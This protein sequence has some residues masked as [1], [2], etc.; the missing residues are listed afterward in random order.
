MTTSTQ[1]PILI[2]S[3]YRTGS[4]LLRFIVDTHPQIYSPPEVAL[5]RTAY[6][7]VRFAIGV[8]G[9]TVEKDQLAAMPPEVLS[10]V[11]AILEGEMSA[12]AAR[13]GKEIWCEKTPSNLLPENLTILRQVFPDARYLCLHRHC[14]DVVPSLLKMAD[15]IQELQ[16]YLMKGG[17]LTA[18]INFWNDVTATLLQH[19]QEHGSRCFRLRYEDMV[20]EPTKVLEPMFRFLGVDWDESLVTGVFTAQHDRGSDDHY[21]SFTNSIHTRSIGSGRSL[22]L[23]GVPEKTLEV[24]RSL[25][26]R[27]GYPE[28]PAATSAA[29]EAVPV[30]DLRWFFE[31]HLPAR[32]RKEPDLCA[33]IAGSYQFVVTGDRGGAWV[34]VPR[35]CRIA[36]GPAAASCS[37]EVSAADLFAIAS[38]ELHPWK[39]AELRR[40]RLSG[41]V[42]P[43]ELE[44]VVRLLHLP[45]AVSRPAL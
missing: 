14:L 8:R 32:I 40:L 36:A 38:G 12:A 39:A 13:K 5:G 10:W 26:R 11:R 27:L 21:I 7:L 15:R 16:P 43:R 34:F 44:K 33:A 22:S 1:P 18:V 4:T 19:E 30:H 29:A 35:E 9:L 37:I 25:L 23:K 3:C 28:L 20:T 24:M 45:K 17:V 2:L 41:D 42:Q 6:D 31:T